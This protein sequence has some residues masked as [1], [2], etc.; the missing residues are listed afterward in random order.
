M[1]NL[2]AEAINKKP[3]SKH[4]QKLETWLISQVQPDDDVFIK[5]RITTE[6]YAE[7][8]GTGKNKAYE[9]LVQASAE[10]LQ[11]LIKIKDKGKYKQSSLISYSECSEEEGYCDIKINLE[12][13]AYLQE[14]AKDESCKMTNIKWLLS[15]QNR[16]SYPLYRILKPYLHQNILSCKTD[17]KIPDLKKQLDCTRKYPLYAEFI[18][19]VILPVQREL[20]EKSDIRFYFEPA[21]K[22]R[23][24]VIS[25]KFTILKNITN[26]DEPSI[27]EF[28]LQILST[29]KD[30][31]GNPDKF[32]EEINDDD[33]IKSVIKQFSSIDKNSMQSQEAVFKA[34]IEHK[35]NEALY[36]RG[37]SQKQRKSPWKPDLSHLLYHPE[38]LKKPLQQLLIRRLTRY[39]RNKKSIMKYLLGKCEI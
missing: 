6:Q 19:N 24:K 32:I 16:Y 25:L 36:C 29:V 27:S 15:C 2:F 39:F 14:L 17:I 37:S 20:R 4:A 38:S 35:K 21:K 5:Y 18:R 22:E 26:S 34:F 31:H 13:R 7:I 12:L 23:K 3:L 33:L 28:G 30:W 9:A 11:Y 1:S 8:S 10:L